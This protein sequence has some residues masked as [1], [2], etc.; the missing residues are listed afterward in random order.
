MIG[1][2]QSY[3][4]NKDGSLRLCV[5]YRKLNGVSQSEA[6]PMPRIDKL[7]DRLGGSTFSNTLDLTRGYWQV[8]VAEADRNKTAFTMLIGL[9]QFKV[10][11]FGLQGALVTFR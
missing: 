6:Y 9:Y 11:P 7:I 3:I 4:L 8:P 1:L 2:H 10:M 5:D